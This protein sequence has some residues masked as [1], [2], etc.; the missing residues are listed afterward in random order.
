MS[1]KPRRS[2]RK[3]EK[4]EGVDEAEYVSSGR[5]RKTPQQ[6]E[7]EA[8]TKTKLT[9]QGKQGSLEWYLSSD[10]S[11]LCNLG[12]NKVINGDTWFCLSSEDRQALFNLL[13]PTASPSYNATLP[14]YHPSIVGT[15]ET[16]KGVDGEESMQLDV[17]DVDVLPFLTSSALATA[18]TT[19]Q[20]HLYSGWYTKKHVENVERYQSGIQTGTI[21]ATWKDEAWE[22]AQTAERVES[23][24]RSRGTSHTL[25]KMLSRGILSIGDVLSYRRVFPETGIKVEKDVLIES[26]SSSN[27]L[28]VVAQSGTETQLPLGML[29]RNPLPPTGGGSLQ[30]MYIQSPEELEQVLLEMDGRVPVAKISGGNSWKKFSL[31]KLKDQPADDFAAHTQPRGPRENRGTLFYLR[32]AFPP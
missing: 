32:G 16:G 11:P 20:D 19:F 12:L 18:L 8:G 27:T 5:K 26:S 24:A 9:A 6:L 14:H 23:E 21:R 31:W 22:E 4:F 28:T 13:P 2:T 30:Q 10:K 7:P 25:G 29:M 1:S 3:S 15:Q 17:Q